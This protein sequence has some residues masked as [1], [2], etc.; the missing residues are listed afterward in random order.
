MM[1]DAKRIAGAAALGTLVAAAAYL[2]GT[3]RAQAPGVTPP[4][5][6]P[7]VVDN[8]FIGP[9][10]HLE[11]ITPVGEPGAPPP[12]R[13]IVDQLLSELGDQAVVELKSGLKRG[14]QRL[15]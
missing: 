11:P 13:Q 5:D 12:A 15:E 10:P 8:G 14:L 6:Q 2:L 1:K 4:V 9:E 3:R 7:E